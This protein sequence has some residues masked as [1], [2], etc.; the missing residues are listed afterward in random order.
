NYQDQLSPVYF[1]KIADFA[2]LGKISE[3][4]DLVLIVSG[5]DISFN[6][7]TNF[8]FSSSTS[9]YWIGENKIPSLNL[10]MT[11]GIWQG[12]GGSAL[13]FEEAIQ[14]FLLSKTAKEKYGDGALTLSKYWSLQYS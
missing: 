7:L 10:E 6:Q 3:K 14:S 4:Y 13:S 1:S 11:S 5:Q 8:P 9:V 2:K 12:G